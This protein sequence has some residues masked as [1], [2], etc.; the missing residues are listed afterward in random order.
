MLINPEVDM[1]GPALL[2]SV[3]VSAANE[4]HRTLL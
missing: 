1:N 4:A 2:Y 3:K